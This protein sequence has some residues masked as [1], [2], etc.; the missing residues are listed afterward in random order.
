MIF[1][2]V[3]ALACRAQ[4]R[5]PPA[6]FRA[7]AALVRVDVQVLNNGRPVGGLE[8]SDFVLRDEGAE[9]KADFFGRES[10]PLEVMVVLDVSGSMGSMLAQMAAAA[11][12]ALTRLHPADRVGVAFFARRITIAEDLT[13]DRSLVERTIRDAPLA[14]GLGAGTSINESL[15]EL[16]AWWSREPPFAGRRAIVLLTDN[17]GM[18]YQAPDDQVIAALSAL[19]IVLNAIVPENAKPP[20]SAAKPGENVN[21]DFTPA[22]VFRLAAETGGE[23][24]QTDKAGARFEQLLEHVRT[25]YSLLLAPAP[26]PPG[27]YRRTEVS[28]AESTRRKF[29]KA[30]VRARAGYVTP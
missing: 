27:L 19:N 3:C 22:N 9:R 6:T 13:S 17:G 15:L 25:R 14:Q 24:M 1:I 21:P 28:L 4:T 10:E 18:H 12:Q 29:P 7:A 11:R 23:V 5:E 26:G 2:I 30:L 16:A 20:R 8:A